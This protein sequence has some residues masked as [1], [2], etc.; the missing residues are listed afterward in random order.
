[1]PHFEPLLNPR[2]TKLEFLKGNKDA[3]Y[4]LKANNAVAT[5]YLNT[6]KGLQ[7]PEDNRA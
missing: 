7:V 5:S 3:V 4:Y 6:F 1:M 2:E